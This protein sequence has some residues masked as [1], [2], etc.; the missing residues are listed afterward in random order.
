MP[1]CKLNCQRSWAT[2]LLVRPPDPIQSSGGLKIKNLYLLND[3]IEFSGPATGDDPDEAGPAEPT[4]SLPY[5]GKT[6][7][8]GAETADLEGGTA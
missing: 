5:N 7:S 2:R 1:L 4:I 6:A 8:E 3:S